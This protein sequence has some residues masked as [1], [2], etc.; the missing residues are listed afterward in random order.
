[1]GFR[2]ALPNPNTCYVDRLSSPVGTLLLFFCDENYFPS[3]LFVVVCH[4]ILIRLYSLNGLPQPTKRNRLRH[5]VL[6]AVNPKPGGL[7]SSYHVSSYLLAN[8]DDVG[9][10]I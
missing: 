9:F 2:L 5:K 6:V 3:L 10:V 1:M 8:S 4:R 7:S